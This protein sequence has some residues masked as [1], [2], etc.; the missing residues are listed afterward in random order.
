VADARGAVVRT[1]DGWRVG[2][3]RFESEAAASE[4]RYALTSQLD[5]DDRLRRAAQLHAQADEALAASAR[6]PCKGV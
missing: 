1:L 3:R 2:F 5:E 4:Y 6:S